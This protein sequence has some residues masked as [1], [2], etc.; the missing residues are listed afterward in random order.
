V[1]HVPVYI[2]FR[3]C[4]IADVHDAVRSIACDLDVE[5][6]WLFVGDMYAIGCVQGIKHGTGAEREGQREG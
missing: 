4:L 2:V 3:I 5:L 1:I 6:Q